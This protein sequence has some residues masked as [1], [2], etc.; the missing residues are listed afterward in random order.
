M[1][2]LIAM[3]VNMPFKVTHVPS[4]PVQHRSDWSNESINKCPWEGDNIEKEGEVALRT[5]TLHK[6][7]VEIG[8]L[9]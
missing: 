9:L 1:E 5:F 2:L 6:M 3:K 8:S 7:L 4:D